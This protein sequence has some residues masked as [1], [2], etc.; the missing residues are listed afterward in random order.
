MSD[1]SF[2]NTGMQLPAWLQT[3]GQ[4]QPAIPMF[5]Q[6]QGMGPPQAPPMISQGQGMSQLPTGPA[7]GAAGAA[8]GAAA[9]AG[10]KG[11]DPATLAAILQLQG[12]KPEQESIERQRKM[13]DMLRAQ[14]QGNLKGQMV[15]QHYVGPSGLDLAGNLATTYLLNE[16]DK[17]AD[18]RSQALSQRESGVGMDLLEALTGKKIPRPAAQAEQAQPGALDSMMSWFKNLTGGGASGS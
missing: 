11:A 16:R 15:G 3:Q 12:M 2:R 5:S 10:Q 14:A 9:A 8:P 7:P 17:D 4:Q 18:K 1:F 6:G 13:A